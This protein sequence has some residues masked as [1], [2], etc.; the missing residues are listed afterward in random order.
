MVRMLPDDLPFTVFV[1]SEQKLQRTLGQRDNFAGEGNFTEE[2][3]VNSTYNNTIA[4]VSR[5]I[6][7]SI[8][9][10]NL[11]SS[12]VKSRDG[13]GFYISIQLQITRS[14]CGVLYVNNVSCEVTDARKGQLIAHVMRE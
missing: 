1:P 9:P 2:M 13:C 5:I 10:L 11:L 3:V 14:S 6:G 7:F 12:Y 4:V 8:V